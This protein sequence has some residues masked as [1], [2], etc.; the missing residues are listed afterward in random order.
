MSEVVTF[1]PVEV[2]VGYRFD[3]DVILEEAK[4]NEFVKLAVLA[5]RPDGSIFVSGNANAGETLIL[6]E[7]AKHRIVFGED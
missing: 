3:P 1:Q 6:M 4:G 7:M 2:G 5:E